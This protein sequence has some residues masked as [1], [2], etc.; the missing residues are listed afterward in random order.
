MS[1]SYGNLST[2][3]GPASPRCKPGDPHHCP[4]CE[5]SNLAPWKKSDLTRELEPEDLHITDSRY[6]VTL[7]LFR[8]AEC[9]FIHAPG[10]DVRRLNALYEQ[11]EDPHYDDTAIGR[12]LQMEWIVRLILRH[13][14]NARTLLDIGAGT[15]MLVSAAERQGL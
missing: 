15:G 4:V 12:T 11:M 13:A 1:T 2:L 8:C 9:G 14:P 3:D 6:G 7:E 10:E 5:G